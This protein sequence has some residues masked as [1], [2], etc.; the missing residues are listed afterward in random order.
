MSPDAMDFWLATVNDGTAALVP[1]VN[2]MTADAIRRNRSTARVCTEEGVASA[3]QQ[4]KIAP[5]LRRETGMGRGHAIAFAEIT[6]R[7]ALGLLTMF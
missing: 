5:Q 7:A 1:K 4:P 6:A 2:A 3:I